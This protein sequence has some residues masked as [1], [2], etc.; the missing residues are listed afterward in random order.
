[1][2]LRALLHAAGV[3]VSAG[4]DP[5]IAAVTADS[6]SVERGALFVAIPG[7]E[8]DGHDYVDEALGTGH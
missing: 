2:K 7:T 3:T 6:R 4:G 1:M 5:D 8:R